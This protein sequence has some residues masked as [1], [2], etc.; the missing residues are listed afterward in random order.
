MNVVIE[1]I[2][3]LSHFQRLFCI[4]FM[5]LICD[6]YVALLSHVACKNIAFIDL[7]AVTTTNFCHGLMVYVTVNVY[8]IELSLLLF[9][10][11]TNLYSGH[12]VLR[13]Q[14][15]VQVMEVMQILRV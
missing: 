7:S 8:N 9:H 15:K 11:V 13:V 4:E 12:A 6:T 2:N 1:F 10:A 5:I 3:T 14:V